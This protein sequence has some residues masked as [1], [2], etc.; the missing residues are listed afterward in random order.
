M[1]W[2]CWSFSRISRAVRAVCAVEMPATVRQK[3]AA[4]TSV[5]EAMSD[6]RTHVKWIGHHERLLV[7]PHHQDGTWPMSHDVLGDAAHE[8]VRDRT[9]AVRADN[10]DVDMSFLRV[11]DDGGGRIV[12]NAHGRLCLWRRQIVT[13]QHV[14]ELTCR[15]LDGVSLQSLEFAG[16]ELLAG[17]RRNGV[18]NMQHVKAGAEGAREV[19]AVDKRGS[20]RFA[21]VRRDENRIHHDHGNPL[22]ALFTEYQGK[23]YAAR[24]V[25]QSGAVIERVGRKVAWTLR[26]LEKIPCDR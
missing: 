15:A 4:T 18:G 8:R 1:R 9:T 13:G 10:D 12:R 24:R 6:P 7:R 19:A 11:I 20:R 17:H 26:S 22:H 25:R 21:E 16:I 3:P 5:R 23:G 2:E 14:I